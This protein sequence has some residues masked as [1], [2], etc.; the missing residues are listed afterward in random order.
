MI[1]STR[2]PLAFIVVISLVAIGLTACQE[3]KQPEPEALLDITQHTKP[4]TTTKQ[5]TVRTGPGSQFKR[6]TE[7]PAKAKIHVVGR[8]GEWLLIVSK[9]GNPPGYITKD[10]A[11]PRHEEADEPETIEAGKFETT[12]D[13][14]VR[15]GP[16]S[17]YSEVAKI[18]NGTKINVVGA[19]KG[20]LKVESKR[21][22]KPGFVEANSAR[23][24]ANQ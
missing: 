8:D 14:A 1:L 6:I 21:G 22:N 4:F 23:R 2:Q 10:A 5:T 17:D 7:I 16:G 24:L 11:Q 15:S 18:P 13:T 9:K 19:E 3:K 20:W 12:A